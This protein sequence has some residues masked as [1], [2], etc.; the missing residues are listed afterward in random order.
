MVPEYFALL[1]RLGSPVAGALAPSNVGPGHT[2]PHPVC[3]RARPT[4]GASGKHRA[5][6]YAAPSPQSHCRACCRRRAR[7]RN[8]PRRPGQALPRHA[9]RRGRPP[10]CPSRVSACRDVLGSVSASGA[11]Q[12][13]TAPSQLAETD[14]GQR[15]APGARDRWANLPAAAGTRPAAQAAR[16]QLEACYGRYDMKRVTLT[17]HADPQCVGP[18]VAAA[19]QACLARR[20]TCGL[21]SSSAEYDWAGCSKEPSIEALS[22][23]NSC[24]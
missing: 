1:N 21:S 19:L 6:F 17:H 16:A 15:T 13:L 7:A 11:V 23:N 22:T 24:A 8:T 10:L 2:S 3:A 14:A 20:S 12:R 5:V 18:A 9:G 4:L